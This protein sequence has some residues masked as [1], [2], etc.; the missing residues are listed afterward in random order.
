LDAKYK[1]TH[2]DK[3]WMGFLPYRFALYS[4]FCSLILAVIQ[5]C[6]TVLIPYGSNDAVT[7]AAGITIADSSTFGISSQDEYA[8]FFWIC[9]IVIGFIILLAWGALLIPLILCE[10][11]C[12]RY[13][14]LFA[15]VLR[16]A[17]YETR[18]RALNCV[19]VYN[20]FIFI[21]DWIVRSRDK[22]QTAQRAW[23]VSYITMIAK[24]IEILFI[25][26]S[27]ILVRVLSCKPDG[28]LVDMPSIRC[29]ESDHKFYAL[30]GM[31]FILPW[32]FLCVFT[33]S[34]ANTFFA[35]DDRV[36]TADGCKPALKAD[37][38]IL[39]SSNF[40]YH[41]FSIRM[42]VAALA[43]I[44]GPLYPGVISVVLVILCAAMLLDHGF[45][46]LHPKAFPSNVYTVNYW[47]GTAI[48]Y[49]S[50]FSLFTTVCL[51]TGMTSTVLYV[52]VFSLLFV[53]VVGAAIL[54]R[55]KISKEVKQS[56]LSARHQEQS[57][58]LRN[59]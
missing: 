55:M 7:K 38:I 52:V 14:K 45:V 42:M 9:V 37:A 56:M 53:W 29:W 24:V 43:L 10:P 35:F 1:K 44:L 5:M 13:F 48:F 39:F 34:W 3:K 20:I 46:P 18:N 25:P 33:M 27:M 6:R 31:F 57:P 2:P 41:L 11:W 23:T 19:W 36:M 8:A 26:A 54:W 47:H 16:V 4:Q 32:Y 15:Q 40:Q 21:F 58:L 59:A 51:L 49:G 17:K 28:E 50:L 30:G 22:P 12:V